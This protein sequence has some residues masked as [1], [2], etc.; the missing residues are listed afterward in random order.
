MEEAV[1]HP[2]RPGAARYATAAGLL[3]NM[4][5][6]GC[7]TSRSPGSRPKASTAPSSSP[8]AAYASR[9]S[10]KIY[11]RLALTDAQ[12]SY[13]RAIGPFLV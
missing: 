6:T 7:V 11:S 4:P 9:Q 8:T 12:A 5:P 1:L 13:D 3:H 10:L 2:R